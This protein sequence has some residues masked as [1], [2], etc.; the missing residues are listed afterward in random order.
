LGGVIRG[1]EILGGVIRGGVIRGGVIRGGT[2]T[3]KNVF[4]ALELNKYP[5]TVTDEHISWGCKT[6]EIKAWFKLTKRE[7]IAFG[8][9]TTEKHWNM[10][11]KTKPFLKIICDE[12]GRKYK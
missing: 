12:T 10:W 2:K 4:F 8:N 6:L 11:L 1:G 5:L 9:G 7:F 3:T